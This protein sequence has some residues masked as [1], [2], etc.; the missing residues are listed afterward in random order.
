M[1]LADTSAWVEFLRGTTSE[2][3][4]RLSTALQ[5]AELATCD[6]VK[7]EVLAG[8]RDAAHMSD[9]DRL[10]ARAV[11]LDTAPVDYRHAAFVY[12][13]CRRRGDTPCSLVDCLIAAVAMRAGAAVLHAD[14]DFG[15]IARHNPLET[16]PAL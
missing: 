4:M 12:L 14:R 3:H 2:A 6:A 1:I 13:S 16:I 10:L 5:D 15:M 9:I 11:M 7:M 8:A